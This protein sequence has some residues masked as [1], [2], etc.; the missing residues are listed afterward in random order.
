MANTNWY[1]G[2]ARVNRLTVSVLL[3]QLLEPE[4][5]QHGRHWQQAAIS[6]QIVSREIKRRGS[7]DFQGFRASRFR[8]LPGGRLIVMLSIV[9]HLLGDS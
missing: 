2:I 8:S 1:A 7:P 4:F 3:H 6:R 5:F 9:I